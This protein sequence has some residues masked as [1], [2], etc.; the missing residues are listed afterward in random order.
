M[1]IWT[2]PVSFTSCMITYRP[3]HV[4]VVGRAGALLSDAHTET[5]QAAI[6]VFRA[7]MEGSRLTAGAGWAVNVHLQH[8][9]IL[10]I[11]KA[12][13]PFKSE[14]WQQLESWCNQNANA[15]VFDHLAAAQTTI[16]AFTSS[17]VTVV[18][19]TCNGAVEEKVTV[20][21]SY[22]FK[23]TLLNPDDKKW[24]F[25]ISIRITNKPVLLYI[26]LLFCCIKIHNVPLTSLPT[27]HLCPSN[28]FP[29]YPGAHLK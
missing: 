16:A 21:N 26:L 20:C 13:S 11:S 4:S 8:S 12:I 5:G 10:I 19:V 2:V 9:I 29:V 1:N 18:A 22:L 17:L 14:L 24:I 23:D 3:Y 15:F 27:T 6:F 25:S 7:K 28:G